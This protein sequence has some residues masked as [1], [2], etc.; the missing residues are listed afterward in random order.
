M[1]EHGEVQTNSGLLGL[2]LLV[3][4]PFATNELCLLPG[5]ELLLCKWELLL[6]KAWGTE[7]KDRNASSL[8]LPG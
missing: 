4:S 2:S 7:G 6:Q 3:R 8:P 5:L 1:S